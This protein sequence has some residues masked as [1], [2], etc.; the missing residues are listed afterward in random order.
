MTI[1]QLYVPFI[2]ACLLLG[3]AIALKRGDVGK[4]SIPLL[5]FSLELPIKNT[6]TLRLLFISG[7]ILALVPYAL[8][9][10]SAL[11]PMHLSMDVYFDEEGIRES[12]GMLSDEQHAD[13]KIQIGFQETQRQYLAS[14]NQKIFLAAAIENFF[15]DR[16]ANTTHA[17]GEIHLVIKKV[18]GIQR[19]HITEAKGSL[20][21]VSQ[22]PNEEAKEVRTFFEKSFSKNDHIA[23]SFF[24]LFR[25]GGIIIKPEFKQIIAEHYRNTNQTFFDHTLLCVTKLRLFPYPSFSRTIYF[26]KDEQ[27]NLAPVAYAIYR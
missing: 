17:N 10:Y 18:A 21:I 11:F 1:L 19:Y 3:V 24:D 13:L 6:S 23:L 9:D 16:V 8:Y 22:R 14:M 26:Y 2:L 27:G 7:A 4:I 15:S 5:F 20:L 12:L 25:Q